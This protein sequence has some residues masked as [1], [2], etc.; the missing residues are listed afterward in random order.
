MLRS[1][2]GSE[3][4]IRDSFKGYRRCRR[5]H[6]LSKSKSNST[7]MS[8]AACACLGVQTVSCISG[9]GQIINRLSGEARAGGWKLEAG[10]GSRSW[11]L[12]AGSWSWKL[13]ANVECR[14]SLAIGECRRPTEPI[15]GQLGVGP[16]VGGRD[17]PPGGRS[18]VGDRNK[19][20]FWA[21]SQ[22]QQNHYFYCT[23]LQFSGLNVIPTKCKTGCEAKENRSN[24]SRIRIKS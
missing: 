21:A 12:E 2:V 16:G 15:L 8:N 7:P 23:K 3:M 6:R 24:S 5:P 1:L 14:L 4:C 17:R 22:K 20:A 19:G 13:D 11:R 18:E 10:A 9:H